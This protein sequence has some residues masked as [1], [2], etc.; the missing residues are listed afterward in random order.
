M[1]VLD[2]ARMHGI[3]RDVARSS[4]LKRREGG[5]SKHL[6]GRVVQVITPDYLKYIHDSEYLYMNFRNF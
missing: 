4:T 1:T 3:E 5:G 2:A 6:T